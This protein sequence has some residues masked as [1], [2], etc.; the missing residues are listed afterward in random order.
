MPSNAALTPA[1]V[2]FLD[3]LVNNGGSSNVAP[4]SEGSGLMLTA[5]AVRPTDSSFF[6]GA[7]EGTSGALAQLTIKGT[8]RPTS[9]REVWEAFGI[10][11]Q[12]YPQFPKIG[13]KTVLFRVRYED[14]ECL[15]RRA[16]L[17]RRKVAPIPAATTPMANQPPVNEPPTEHPGAF[18]SGGGAPQRPLKSQTFPGSQSSALSQVPLHTPEAHRYP[19]HATGPV[20]VIA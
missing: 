12:G 7:G 16:A 20:S 10:W 5:E 15:E 1:N 13:A 14:V 8:R 2:S 11:A 4:G 6:V 17:R 9:V 18:S 19:P 3:M